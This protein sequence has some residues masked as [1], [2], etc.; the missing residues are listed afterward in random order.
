MDKVISNY[1][2]NKIFRKSFFDSLRFPEGMY[3]EDRYLM[4]EILDKCYMARLSDYGMY[5]Y[6]Q[7]SNQVTSKPDSAFI[8]ES[9]IKADLNFVKHTMHFKS[10]RSQCIERYYNCL[11][12][13]D[14]IK[15]SGWTLGKDVLHDL[16]S[17][18]PSCFII[19]LSKVPL[20]IKI[21]MLKILVK[22]L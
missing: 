14:K 16:K 3:F 4:S 8:L 17:N 2:C 7:R 5:Y 15:S 21:N 1:V 6:Y 19:L 18:I 13:L 10:L 20:G 22:G 11:F 12:Y 9:K